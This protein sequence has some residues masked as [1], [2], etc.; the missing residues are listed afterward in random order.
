MYVGALGF[1]GFVDLEDRLY[2]RPRTAEAMVAAMAAEFVEANDRTRPRPMT[3]RTLYRYPRGRR[4]DAIPLS[5][6]LKRPLANTEVIRL[7]APVSLDA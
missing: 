7:E 4:T 3:V 5:P 2:A 1:H 6:A